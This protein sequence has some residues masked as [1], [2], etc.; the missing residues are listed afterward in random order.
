MSPMRKEVVS[1]NALSITTFCFAFD[2]GEHPG[3]YVP[4]TS[5]VGGSE[6][7]G[8]NEIANWSY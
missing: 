5:I 7:E 8:S 2:G 1:H 6:W 4:G 3:K